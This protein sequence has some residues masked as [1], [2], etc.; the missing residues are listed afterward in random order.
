MPFDKTGDWLYHLVEFLSLLATLSVIFAM[1][2]PFKSIY[3]EKYDKFG[4]LHVDPAYGIVY[5]LVPCVVLSIVCHSD[6]NKEFFSD[7]SWTLSMY[8]EAVAL[9]PQLYMFQKQAGDQ[10]GAVEVTIGHTI[11]SLG[12]SRL[13]ELIFWVRSFKELSN[14]FLGKVP[15]YLVLFSQII[16][17]IIL[18]D[19]FYYYIVSVSKGVP[20]ELPSISLSSTNV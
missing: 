12:A 8:L 15:G 4:N 18:G 1:L 20:M 5:L 7:V 17:I 14:S 3:E 13:F 11:F 16:H 6:L 2:S 9:V 10:E 19:F